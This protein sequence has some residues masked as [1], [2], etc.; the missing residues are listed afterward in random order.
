MGQ[1]ATEI[2]VWPYFLDTFTWKAECRYQD[3]ITRDLRAK[4]CEGRK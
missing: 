3:I 4:D 1:T 2:I